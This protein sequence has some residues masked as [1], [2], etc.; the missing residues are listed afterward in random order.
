MVTLV[1]VLL[2]ILIVAFQSQIILLHT[3]LTC[4]SLEIVIIID[5]FF[6]RTYEDQN[7]GNFSQKRNFLVTPI[8]DKRNKNYNKQSYMQC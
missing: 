3:L 4:T 7:S 8:D 2:Q 5:A 1:R 6:Q